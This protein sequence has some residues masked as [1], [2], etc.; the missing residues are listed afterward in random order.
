[1]M[2]GG[3]GFERHVDPRYYFMDTGESCPPGG[4]IALATAPYSALFTSASACGDAIGQNVVISPQAHK[5]PRG[6]Y[7]LKQ[8]Y[9]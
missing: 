4:E 1:M 8:G 7:R 2:G 9:K 3:D 6:C 5:A